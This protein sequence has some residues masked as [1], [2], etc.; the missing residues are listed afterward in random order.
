MLFLNSEKANIIVVGIFFFLTECNH[1]IIIPFYFSKKKILTLGKDL[2][3]SYK[4]LFYKFNKFYFLIKDLFLY[5]CIRSL[6]F[7]LALIDFNK[8]VHTLI[9]GLVI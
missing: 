1:K 4:I 7:V 5:L 8:I 6:K 2:A 3:L 9:F